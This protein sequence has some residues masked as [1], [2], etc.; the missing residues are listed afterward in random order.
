MTGI[1]DASQRKAA[2]AVGRACL[3]ALV[4]AI[5]AE[6]YVR[7]RLV[8]AGDMAGKAFDVMAHERLFRFGSRATSRFSPST[9]C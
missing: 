5:F 4:P 3:A 1:I 8:V 6:F 7:G 9:S 2:T